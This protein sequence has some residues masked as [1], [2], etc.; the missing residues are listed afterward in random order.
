MKKELKILLLEDV[1]DDAGLVDHTLRKEK[2]SFVSKRVDTREGFIDALH[3]FIPDVVLSDHGLPQFNSIEA[4]QLCREQGLT[5]PFILVT[6]TVSEE[7]AVNCLKQGAD[8]Y[9][10]KSN[11]S[12]LPS[13]IVSSLSKREAEE[14]KKIAEEELR[15]Q[16]GELIEAND[17][18]VKT[19]RELDN[20]VYSVSHN[21]RAPLASVLGLINIAKM[22]DEARGKHFDPFFHMMEKSI[23]KLDETLREI[24]DYSRN[25]R[26]DVKIEKIDPERFFNE[27][28]E[29][30]KYLSN[31][32]QVEVGFRSEGHEGV[33]SDAY[34]IKMI[35]NN[36]ISNAIKYSDPAKSKKLLNVTIKVSDTVTMVFEDNGIGMRESLLPYI[37]NMF[38][39]GTEKSEGAGLGLYIVKEAVEKLGG[40]I[41]VTS[42]EGVGS[43]FTITL[44]NRHHVLQHG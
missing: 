5:A 4:L 43:V 42:R 32:H 9:V 8:D 30:L 2:L 6:G 35:F 22:D 20:F 13:A 31:T 18:L 23:H 29:K 15:K 3:D 41:D 26:G 19:N 37:F 40:K 28:L 11:L 25:S 17:K 10:L 12:R 34:R 16:N 36:M 14:K 21:L 38:Y 33:Y 39:R 27:S 7:F 44:A 24:L 1:A